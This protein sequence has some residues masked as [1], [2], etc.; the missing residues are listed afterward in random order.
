MRVEAI[1][2]NEFRIYLSDEEI[3]FIFGGYELIGYE[4]KTEK[5]AM[6]SLLRLA[7]PPEVYPLDCNKIML[8]VKPYNSGCCI[9]FKKV[10]S[11][12]THSTAIKES[13]SVL[14]IKF[15]NS[16]EMITGICEIYCRKITEAGELYTINNEYYLLLYGMDVKKIYKI[17]GKSGIDISDDILKIEY[18][19][20]YGIPVCKEN[21]VYKI[22]S[23]FY[24]KLS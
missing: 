10:Y 7:L 11:D 8:E 6:N 4:N 15:K 5:A 14:L 1:G 3:S 17:I 12:I 20:E 21:A 16:E 13:N 23:S 9:Y 22:G 2:K 18:I 19:K 24:K